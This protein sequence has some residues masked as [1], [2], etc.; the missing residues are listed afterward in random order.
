MHDVFKAWCIDN[1]KGYTPSPRD[2]K[3]ELEEML[4]VDKII[5]KTH[6]QTYYIFT[7]TT[8]AKQDYVKIYGCDSSII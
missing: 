4:D 3:K 8:K 1:N 6:G 7:L 5:R 2:F